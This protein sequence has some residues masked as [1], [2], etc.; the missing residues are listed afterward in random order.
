MDWIQ[1][2]FMLPQE[3]TGLMTLLMII[4]RLI[5]LIGVLV[6][7]WGACVATYHFVCHCQS[8]SR[9][10]DSVDLIRLQFGR[11][12][13]LGLEFIVAADVIETTMAPD[14]YSLGILAGLAAI[15]TLLTYFM[16][17]EVTLLGKNK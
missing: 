8:K 7:F 17:R 12:I 5:S 16:N 10:I 11:T 13:I 6:I 14:Y 2:L 1:N 3:A 4:R 15:R 9:K